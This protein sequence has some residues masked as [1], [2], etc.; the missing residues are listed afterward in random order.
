MMADQRSLRFEGWAIMLSLWVTF[1][2][3]TTFSSLALRTLRQ[4]NLIQLPAN[5]RE[6]V[7]LVLGVWVTAYVVG[8]V[9]GFLHGNMEARRRLVFSTALGFVIGLGW[10]LAFLGTFPDISRDS[11]KFA[12]DLLSLRG[13]PAYHVFLLL[14]LFL[15][16]GITALATL[17]GILLA[18]EFRPAEW[19]LPETEPRAVI[20]AA[21]LPLAVM[22]LVLG[23]ANYREEETLNQI[24]MD[25]RFSGANSGPIYFL[26]LN[27]LINPTINMF[28]AGLIGSI[29]GVYARG[30]TAAASAIS[31]GAGMAF[32]VILL[33]VIKTVLTPYAPPG[34]FTDH[35]ESLQAPRVI[36]FLLLA[37]GIPLVAMTSAYAGHMLRDHYKAN[38]VSR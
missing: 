26:Y 23:V 38:S 1:A 16:T 36:Y 28:L 6:A 17:T 32:Y 35:L 18:Q 30:T 27:T 24:W 29:I 12:V 10:H 31:A 13:L 14:T 21:I 19:P 9:I 5:M 34:Y 25:G 15:G 11:Y 20:V 2:L 33:M 7:W 37:V 8:I 3:S 22:M 4:D